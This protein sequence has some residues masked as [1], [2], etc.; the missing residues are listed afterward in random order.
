MIKKAMLPRTIK[1]SL[2]WAAS[3]L[4]KAGV[5]EARLDAELLLCH[6]LAISEGQR[7]EDRA[8]A[9]RYLRDEGEARGYPSYSPRNRRAF[10]SRAWLLAHPEAPLTVDEVAAYRRLVARRARREPLPY[11]TGHREFYGLDFYVDRRVLIPRP[12]TEL[13]VE[14]ALRIAHSRAGLCRNLE[15]EG[16]RGDTSL[17]PRRTAVL[18]PCRIADVGAGSGAIAVTLAVHLPGA[19]I[20]ATETCPEALEVAAHNARR[21]GVAERVHLLVGDLLA[22]LPEPVDIIVANLPYVAAHE[23]ATLPPEVRLYEPRSALDGGPDG[24]AVIAR[25]LAQAPAYLRPRGAVI[26]EIGSTQGEAVTA[27][28]RQHFPTASIAVHQDLAGR[29]RVVLIT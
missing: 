6:L 15:R 23:W 5:E 10:P 2:H 7:T 28:A 13:L 14:H 24:L 27:L 4:K 25:L 21:H 17:A 11:I 16:G 19:V 12:E 29:D 26:L 20:Y 8:T 22:P 9:P 18:S 3:E 1:E